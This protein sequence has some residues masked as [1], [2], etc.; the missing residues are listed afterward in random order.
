M[1]SVGSSIM[2]ATSIHQWNQ[3]TWLRTPVSTSSGWYQVLQILS[4]SKAKSSYVVNFYCNG[5]FKGKEVKVSFLPYL[6]DRKSDY[7]VA[8]QQ[9]L[10]VRTPHGFDW[11]SQQIFSDKI[12]MK[13]VQW[14]HM[15]V[16]GILKYCIRGLLGPFQRKTIF[17]IVWC[18]VSAFVRRKLH[19][20]FWCGWGQSALGAFSSWTWFSGL[21]SCH[22]FPS[23]TS[24]T[25]V[26]SQVWSSVHFL[27]VSFQEIQL[28][29]WMQNSQSSLSRSHSGWDLSSVWVYTVSAYL[30]T[31]SC[32]VYF[33]FLGHLKRRWAV[34]VWCSIMWFTDNLTH[35]K[36]F[37]Q[38]LYEESMDGKDN[39]VEREIVLC[40]FHTKCDNHGRV[41]YSADN[42]ASK[43]S[44]C[45][46]YSQA[47]TSKQVLFGK[48]IKTFWHLFSDHVH[49]LLHVM[50]YDLFEREKESKIIVV[51]TSKQ[52]SFNP[53]ISIADVSK[54]L[55]Y[56]CEDTSKLCTELS[57][58]R[59][60]KR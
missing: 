60:Y 4:K 31:A 38:R 55:I 20:R 6:F 1:L 52:S 15:L 28:L 16:S 18:C 44:S 50:W 19:L 8:S 56:A 29:D 35:L 33:G 26:H 59:P 45:I 2:T 34:K 48:I 49:F 57:T 3:W 24:P 36:D 47:A 22:C 9:V 14:K 17:W 21:S 30:K 25:Y 39:M 10:S 40:K 37:Y 13:S 54:P 11:T 43:H 41:M 7:K 53:I 32:G 42:P 23:A 5:Q 51:D 27:D 46:I 58:Q 12:H